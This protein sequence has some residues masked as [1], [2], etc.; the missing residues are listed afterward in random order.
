MLTLTGLIILLLGSSVYLNLL[1]MILWFGLTSG[2]ASTGISIKSKYVEMPITT[3]DVCALT[4]GNIMTLSILCTNT[5]AGSTCAGDEGTGLFREIDG[6]RTTIGIG[7]FRAAIGC[8][9]GHP[10]VF[11]RVKEFVDWICFNEDNPPKD[12]KPGDSCICECVCHTCPPETVREE[13]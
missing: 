1:M 13:L 9:L 12:S 8:T 11:T 2:E 4:F 7:S 3:N 6:V 5:S 10:A